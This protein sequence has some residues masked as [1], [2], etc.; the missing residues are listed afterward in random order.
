MVRIY[1][2]EFQPMMEVFKVGRIKNML[3][4]DHTRWGIKQKLRLPK[5]PR[6]ILLQLR[7]QLRET[8]LP[9]LHPRPCWF[10]F[11]TTNRSRSRRLH[12][13]RLLMTDLYHR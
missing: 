4:L 7:Q 5:N 6:R 3:I 11:L 10:Q 12:S 8:L 1:G 2:L 9:K 13:R